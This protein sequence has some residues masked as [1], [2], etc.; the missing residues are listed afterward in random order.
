MSEEEAVRIP[1]SPLEHLIGC[2]TPTRTVHR[3]TPEP[4][5][6]A[7]LPIDLNK[8]HPRTCSVL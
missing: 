8:T 2:L 1:R 7:T 3:D 5:T 6:G 4:L